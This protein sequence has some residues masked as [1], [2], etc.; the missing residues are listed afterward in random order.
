M[1]VVD[2]EDRL[3]QPGWFAIEDINRR[4]EAAYLAHQ[5]LFDDVQHKMLADDVEAVLK[6]HAVYY[7][8]I[9]QTCRKSTRNR[10]A[11][12][13]VKI[14]K[15]KFRNGKDAVEKDLVAMGFSLADIDY[16]PASISLSVRVS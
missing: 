5:D 3:N 1:N 13:E 10:P 15:V 16:K 11:H 12:T 14:D 9:Y 8:N 4:S 7:S 6:R 2:T